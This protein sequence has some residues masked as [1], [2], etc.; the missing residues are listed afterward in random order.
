MIARLVRRLLSLVIL[1]CVICGAIAAWGYAQFVRPGPLAFATTV[2]IEHGTSV[3][4]IATRLA[5]ADVIERPDLFRLGVRAMGLH[6]ALK[7]GE[8]A[9]PARISQRDMALL[10]QSGKTVVR[11]LTVAE[12]L[13]TAQVLNKI[14]A[15]GGLIGPLG[16]SPGEGRLLP[17]T[18]HFSYG[19]SR[20]EMANRM[21]GSMADLLAKSWPGRN[22]DLAIDTAEQALILASIVERETAVPQERA[23]IAAV[24]HNRLR[25][26]MRLQSDPTVAYGL[27]PVDGLQTP[28]SRA[29][30]KQ[31]TPYNTY[32]IDGLPPGPICNPGRA[33]IEAV[34]HPAETDELYFVADGTGGHAF[35]RT[36][37]EHNRNVERW[38]RF[39]KQR[40]E[41]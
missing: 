10:L 14:A 15:T 19:D 27:D 39:Q 31:P 7:A 40:Q 29:D 41:R 26:G 35:A 30:L 37:K 28:L 22:P 13:T 18:Y 38:R 20:R 8:Y 2:I 34:L 3:E 32:L 6:A 16:Q 4:G 5:Q 11:R 9:V 12:G 36:L 25:K 33:A 21:L 24:F 23:R 17:E 1:L